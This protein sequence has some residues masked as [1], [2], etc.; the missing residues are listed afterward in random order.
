MSVGAVGLCRCKLIVYRL[1]AERVPV[2]ISLLL[3]LY[4]RTTPFLKVICLPLRSSALV[5]SKFL[6]AWGMNKTFCS[7]SVMFWLVTR[8]FKCTTPCPC[9]GTVPPTP[10]DLGRCGVEQ[11]KHSTLTTY[12]CTGTAVDVPVTRAF[13]RQHITHHTHLTHTL[14]L[15]VICALPFISGTAL[16]VWLQLQMEVPTLLRSPPCLQKPHESLCAVVVWCLCCYVNVCVHPHQHRVG[17]IP[18]T[19]KNFMPLRHNNGVHCPTHT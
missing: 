4:T 17:N 7:I 8:T 15:V 2:A 12:M 13:A 5:E 10:L 9:A 1:F 6:P 11:H 16:W 3:L 19:G 14:T 18:I